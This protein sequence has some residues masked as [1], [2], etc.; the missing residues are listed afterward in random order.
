M[1]FTFAAPLFRWEGQAAWHFVAL[2][3]AVADEIEDSPIA[4]GGFG[5]VR[6]EVR[7]GSTSWLTS[8][9]PDTARRTYVLP[10]K[11]LVRTREDLVEGDVV[12]VHLTTID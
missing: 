4:R 10:V 1:E 8:L 2:P 5:S 11:K 3:E 6:V 9:F 7:V 12:T